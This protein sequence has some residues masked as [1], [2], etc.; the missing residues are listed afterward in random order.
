MNTSI[1]SILTTAA[2]AAATWGVAGAAN[3]GTY[4]PVQQYGPV[5]PWQGERGDNYD[6]Y[7]HDR[8]AQ[9]EACRAPRWEPER[10]YMPGDTVWRKGELYQARGVSARVYNVNSPPEWTPNYWIP[11][12]C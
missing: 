8:Y 1:K 6:R 7:G 9:H 11:V 3:A 2:L 10:R 5:Q 4:M 12:R